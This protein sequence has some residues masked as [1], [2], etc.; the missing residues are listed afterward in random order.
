MLSLQTEGGVKNLWDVMDSRYG[1]KQQ[2]R[3]K[4]LHI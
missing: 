2:L 1:E 4:I 3:R